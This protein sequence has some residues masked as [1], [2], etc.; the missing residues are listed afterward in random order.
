MISNSPCSIF[1][2]RRDCC[3]RG[4]IVLMDNAEQT[5]PFKASQV[6]LADNREWRELGSAVA[7]HSQSAPFDNARASIRWTSFIILQAPN[8]IPVGEDLRS[9][10]QV[11]TKSAHFDGIR[12]ELPAQRT[13][14][15]LH[16]QALLRAFHDDGSVPE[17]KAVGKRADRSRW[18]RQRLLTRSINLCAFPEG[19]QYTYEVDLAWEADH[20][21]PPLALVSCADATLVCAAAGPRLVAQPVIVRNHGAAHHA[22]ARQ[23]REL[24][25]G[26]SLL[27]G[28]VLDLARAGAELPSRSRRIDVV[29]SARATGVRI[30]DAPLGFDG[31]VARSRVRR[32]P[33]ATPHAQPQRHPGPAA[34]GDGD[35]VGRANRLM[36]SAPRR[37][38]AWGCSA[39]ACSRPR[40]GR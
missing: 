14:G 33:P 31:L 9:W 34:R 37:D 30:G 8:H 35:V 36:C 7:S 13:A 40:P 19:A 29:R 10:G 11:R 28:R 18:Q 2:C 1:K 15:W 23:R 24:V 21:C 22:V 25:G 12:L 5:G 38:G 27:L 39:R 20:A 26:A 4:G 3:G 16:Y 32:P 6:F 17:Q